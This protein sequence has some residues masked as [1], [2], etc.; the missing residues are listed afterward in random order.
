M[1]GWVGGWCNKETF[2]QTW[3]R[4]DLHSVAALIG[5]ACECNCRQNISQLCHQEHIL[6]FGI[7]FSFTIFISVS[8]LHTDCIRFVLR[9]ALSSGAL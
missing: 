1:G 3:P 6:S 2:P 8:T 7:C 9:V 4:H 5:L